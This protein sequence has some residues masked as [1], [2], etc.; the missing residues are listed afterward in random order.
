MIINNRQAALWLLADM[1]LN[2][3][4]LSIVKNIGGELP[5]WQIVFLRSLIGLLLLL[6]WVY[7]KYGTVM[8]WTFADTPGLH[9]LRIALSSITLT[10]S[11]YAVAHIPLALFTALGF[12][13]PLLFLMMSALVL[14]EVIPARSWL[15]GLFCLAGVVVAVTPAALTEGANYAG[16]VAMAVVVVAGT[17]AIIVTRKL[18]QSSPLILMINYTVGLTLFTALPAIVT[19]QTVHLPVWLWL[20]AIGCLAQLGQYCFI[21]AHKTGDAAILGP[22]GFTSL[23]VSTIAGIVFF[24]EYP[25]SHTIAGALIIIVS[26]LILQRSTLTKS[27]YS[28]R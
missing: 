9:G 13:R 24:G 25:A 10:A 28:D 22:I 23:I 3:S 4:A 18:K 11:F 26:V 15:A 21:V 19:W 17:S 1:C 12:T 8:V 2:I 20:L 16:L 7:R 5:V 27:A 6:P 14:K